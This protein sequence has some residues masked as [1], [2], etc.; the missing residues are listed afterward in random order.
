MTLPVGQIE[1]PALRYRGGK[2]RLAPWIISH[3]PPHEC[4]VEPFMGACSVLLQK[5]P[6]DFEVINDL[7]GDVVAFFEMLR[8]RPD[9]LQQAIALTPFSRAE[10]QACRQPVP[11]GT[12]DPQLEQARRL[13]TRCWQGRGSS[14][15]DGGWRFQK[16]WN[17]WKMNTPVYF[18]HLGH[19]ADMALRLAH[20]QIENTDALAVIRRF[21]APTTCFYIDPPYVFSTRVASVR[22]LYTAEMDDRAH[23]ALAETLHGI[24]G[25]AL[26]SGYPSALYDRLYGHW[27]C[28]TTTAYAE[29]QKATTEALWINPAADAAL[30]DDLGPLFDNTEG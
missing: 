29:Q 3:L 1:R 28:E 15:S 2:W 12:R 21:D 14:T 11:E 5:P 20:V 22:R 6:S 24:Q 19:L 8:T 13:Y 9:E 23:E 30:S 17:G 18:K 25:M 16:A 7:D 26:V 10:Y 27:R 4:Y